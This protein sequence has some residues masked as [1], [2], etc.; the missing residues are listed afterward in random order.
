MYRF[1]KQENDPLSRTIT[2]H[3]RSLAHGPKPGFDAMPI[4]PFLDMWSYMVDTAQPLRV[5]VAAMQVR[6]EDYRSVWL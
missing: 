1:V 6:D 3:P 4:S 2:L 5:T